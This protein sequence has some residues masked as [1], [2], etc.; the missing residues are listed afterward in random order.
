M[1]KI[2]L[3]VPLGEDGQLMTVPL[4]SLIL[5]LS[6]I[7]LVVTGSVRG[8]YGMGGRLLS[9]LF[10]HSK[11]FSPLGLSR[12]VLI[13]GCCQSVVLSKSLLKED[14][15]RTHRNWTTCVVAWKKSL[16]RAKVLV[17]KSCYC[18]LHTYGWLNS[19]VQKNLA[20]QN[21]LLNK[22][23]VL[24]SK[25]PKHFAGVG[26]QKLL[27]HQLIPTKGKSLYLGLTH[28]KSHLF[29]ARTSREILQ[30]L[31]GPTNIWNA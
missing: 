20:S 27:K 19:L 25:C 23:R 3:N 7:S 26:G 9:C 10:L 15:G 17:P 16:Q 5:R 11:S 14:L 6:G 8:T 30:I 4:G 31:G 22:S 18:Q 2:I 24:N 28:S 13:L 29:P 12:L 1:P 21:A